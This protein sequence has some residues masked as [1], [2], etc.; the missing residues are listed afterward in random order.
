MLRFVTCICILAVAASCIVV[1]EPTG[2]A[3]EITVF[4]TGNGL[5]VLKPC[6]CSGGQLGGL[7][8]R[9]A[10]LSGVSANKRMIVDTGLFVEGDGEQDLIKFDIMMRALGLLDYDLVN[11]TEEDI[12]IVE[13]LGL[14]DGIGSFFNVITSR[15]Q[16]DVNLPARFTKNF[17]LKDKTIAVTVAAFDVER[18]SVEEIEKLFMHKQGKQTVNILILNRC[19]SGC[20]QS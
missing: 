1:S 5:G 4:L 16:S 14:K 10:V 7:D 3:D 18:M 13:N 2:K 15:R 17:A 20:T 11:L 12:T 9:G 19:T 8:R 6:G